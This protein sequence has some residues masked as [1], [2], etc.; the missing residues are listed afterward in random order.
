MRSI[1]LLF[2]SK[3]T[4]DKMYKM[5]NKRKKSFWVVALDF[6]DLIVAGKYLTF[7][8]YLMNH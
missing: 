6:K 2:I 7:M 5:E 3:G 1:R 4:M 8:A